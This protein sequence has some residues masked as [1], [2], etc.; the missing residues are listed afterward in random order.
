[1]KKKTFRIER[2]ATFKDNPR[3]ITPAQREELASSMERLGDISGLVFNRRSGQWVGGNQR[4]DIMEL[5][6]S[7]FE[8]NAVQTFDLPDKTGT[9]ALGMVIYKGIPFACRVV[10]WDEVTEREANIAANAKGGAWDFQIIRQSWDLPTMKAGGFDPKELERIFFAQRGH[11]R[12]KSVEIQPAFVLEIRCP[13]EA[14]LQKLF[15]QY[16]DRYSC[17]VLTF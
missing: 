6:A 4:A 12:D 14:T 16:K 1:M 7:P 5:N 17:K 10:D 9:V 3:K 15:D 2:A 13:D 8:I 11:Q